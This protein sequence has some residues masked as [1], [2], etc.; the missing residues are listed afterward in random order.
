MPSNNALSLDR[1]LMGSPSG[2]DHV[3][4]FDGTDPLPACANWSFDELVENKPHFIIVSTPDRHGNRTEQG[5]YSTGGFEESKDKPDRT[6]AWYYGYLPTMP[7]E[8]I[9][10]GHYGHYRGLDNPRPLE[11]GTLMSALGNSSDKPCSLFLLASV[12]R[13]RINPF[14][15]A[16]DPSGSWPARYE[17]QA[18][19]AATAAP[20]SPYEAVCRGFPKIHSP[21]VFE[22]HLELW[23]QTAKPYSYY[24]GTS[25]SL[26]PSSRKSPSAPLV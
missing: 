6:E 18:L 5:L 4:T 20:Y 10:M 7:N 3:L 23:R 14:L 9:Y 24:L 12:L 16:R 13:A 1:H 15:A 26:R 21:T 17:E 25:T 2:W 22:H 8:L 19:R 11:S